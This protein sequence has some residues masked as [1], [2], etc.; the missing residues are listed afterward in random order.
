LF[1]KLIPPQGWILDAGC[2]PGH[3]SVYLGNL[4]FNVVGIDLSK[5]ALQIAETIKLT[6]T[7]FYHR[8]M[9]DTQLESEKFNGVWSC[10]SLN[11]TPRRL[12][13]DIFNE[14]NRVLVPGGVLAVTVA[15]GERQHFDGFGRF[16]ES[17]PNKDFVVSL[18]D[19]SGF[20]AVYIKDE[21]SWSSTENSF[22]SVN[23]VTV[24]VRKKMI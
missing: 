4:G 6:N 10:A 8:N 13:I 16:F 2:G 18:L 7:S 17:L 22:I 21:L 9:M 24:C 19:R 1:S 11:H 14:F 3:H 12:L 23:W 5:E 15:I 20:V